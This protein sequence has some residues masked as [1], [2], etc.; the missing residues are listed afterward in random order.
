MAAW[1]GWDLEVPEPQTRDD[2][3]LDAVRSGEAR[4]SVAD[5]F[6]VSVSTVGR[7]VRAAGA[8]TDN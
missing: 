2:Q 7:I 8:T 1:L 6:G 3:I 4:R 5:R